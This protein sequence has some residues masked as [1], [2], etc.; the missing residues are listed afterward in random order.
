M[1]WKLGASSGE[2]VA[3]G[4]MLAETVDCH[5]TFIV[6]SIPQE[7]FSDVEIGGVARFRLSGETQERMGRVM[8]VT[9]DNNLLEDRNLASTP[10]IQ[11]T[12][13]AMARIA[14][15]PSENSDD[16]CM[17]GRTARI[18]LPTRGGALKSWLNLIQNIIS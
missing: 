1:L 5:N 16:K 18:L 10:M 12:S 2:R 7:R 14:L 15:S 17:V 9:G 3:I 6:A 11:K 13:S 8:S 4:G